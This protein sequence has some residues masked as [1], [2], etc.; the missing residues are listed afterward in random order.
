LIGQIGLLLTVPKLLAWAC[1]L[2]RGPIEVYEGLQRARI[3][4]VDAAAGQEINWGIEHVP[5][6]KRP[7]HTQRAASARIP[8]NIVAA[9]PGNGPNKQSAIHSH[10]PV[11]DQSM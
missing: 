3:P 5:S 8:L 10:A 7:A 1:R 11:S 6:L 2:K 4:M 9:V